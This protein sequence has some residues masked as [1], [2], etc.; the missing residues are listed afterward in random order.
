MDLINMVAMIETG[1]DRVMPEELSSLVR[2]PTNGEDYREADDFIQAMNIFAEFQRYL[3]SIDLEM[4]HA[5]LAKTL[6]QWTES[7]GISITALYEVMDLRDNII[8]NLALVGFDPY[9]RDASSSSLSRARYIRLVKQCLF[10]GYKMNIAVWNPSEKK[11]YARKS[12]LPIHVDA[13]AAGG[14]I[15][16]VADIVK[17]GDSN[18]KYILYRGLR[19]LPIPDST[20]YRVEAD[21]ISVLDGYIPIDVNFDVL[22]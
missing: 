19:C 10:E 11:Y 3:Q 14:T 20:V 7:H 16:D 1:M 13:S 15:Q 4:G 12:H 5:K 6:Q 8:N 17:H 21:T 9:R 2:S 18:P 22:V